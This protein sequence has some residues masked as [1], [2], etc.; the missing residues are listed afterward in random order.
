MIVPAVRSEE[1]K[2][3]GGA[4]WVLV[5]SAVAVLTLVAVVI[6]VSYEDLHAFVVQLLLF[7]KFGLLYMGLDYLLTKIN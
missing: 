7:L 2:K 3:G 6:V 1:K 4:T 5:A